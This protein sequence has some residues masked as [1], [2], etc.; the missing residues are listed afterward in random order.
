MNFYFIIY[1]FSLQNIKVVTENII[2][3][4]FRMTVIDFNYENLICEIC[5]DI[6]SIVDNVCFLTFVLILS[7]G[8]HLFSKN[9]SV[10]EKDDL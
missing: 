3:M 6:G 5:S 1:S 4:Y 7:N 10:P 8:T 9:T 2:A